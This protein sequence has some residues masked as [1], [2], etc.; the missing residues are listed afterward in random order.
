MIRHE[1]ASLSEMLL[2][3]KGSAEP[4]CFTA[5]R[6]PALLRGGKGRKRK[7]ERRISVRLDAQR[8]QR[9][10]LA[11]AHRDQSGQALILAALDHYLEQVIPKLIE[12]PCRCLSEGKSDRELCVSIL[13]C[14]SP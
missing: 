1:A 14:R 8:H 7:G 4:T 2:V 13:P 12:G 3:T 5:R 11:A 6:E 10:R 9:L